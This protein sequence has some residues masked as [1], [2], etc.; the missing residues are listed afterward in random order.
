[1]IEPSSQARCGTEMSTA[2]FVI[3]RQSAG[4]PAACLLP[5]SFLTPLL[6]VAGRLLDSLRSPYGTPYGSPPGLLTES[7]RDSSTVRQDS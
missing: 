3:R 2:L 1:M 6:P 5:L 4:G 7:L